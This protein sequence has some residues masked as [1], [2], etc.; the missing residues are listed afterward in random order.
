M[1]S[2]VSGIKRDPDCRKQQLDTVDMPTIHQVTA[3]QQ[4]VC[5]SPVLFEDQADFS[6]DTHTAVSNPCENNAFD[7]PNDVIAKK[8]RIFKKRDSLVTKNKKSKHVDVE[9]SDKKEVEENTGKN[10]EEVGNNTGDLDSDFKGESYGRTKCRIRGKV[11]RVMADKVKGG[12]KLST[13]GSLHPETSRK[14]V[15]GIAEAPGESYLQISLSSIVNL[16]F[17][18]LSSFRKS[19]VEWLVRMT[20]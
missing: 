14:P 6:T 17:L 3:Q 7:T 10:D 20:C 18:N 5:T 4:L 9:S 13:D 11:S 16:L 2:T 8:K 12:R 19:S 1:S 15:D